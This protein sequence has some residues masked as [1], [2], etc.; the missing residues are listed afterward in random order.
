MFI[1]KS[2][3]SMLFFIM[4]T[5]KEKFFVRFQQKRKNLRKNNCEN[6]EKNTLL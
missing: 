3:K 2:G 1:F 4:F 5:K 6:V